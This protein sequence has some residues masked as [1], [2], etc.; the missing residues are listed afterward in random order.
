MEYACAERDWTFLF[1][2]VRA[3]RPKTSE[4]FHRGPWGKPM[5]S[6]IGISAQRRDP[7]RALPHKLKQSRRNDHITV[8]LNLAVVAHYEVEIVRKAVISQ[9]EVKTVK[10]RTAGTDETLIYL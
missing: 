2:T 7:Q 8:G 10:F 9:S 5:G 3:A 1:M 6:A 4:V